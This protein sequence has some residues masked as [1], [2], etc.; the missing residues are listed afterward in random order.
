MRIK[1]KD[2]RKGTLVLVPL[3]QDD[4]WLLS[5]V[6][7]KGALVSGHTTRKIK[8]SE[9]KVDKK[10][11]YLQI[12]TEKVEYVNESLRVSGKS[13]TE[14]DDIPKG[15]YH[16]ISFAVH[17]E[18][19]I[20]QEWMKYQLDKIDESA[21]E[22]SNILL[23]V[24]DRQEVFFAQ[25]TQEGYKLLSS[26]EGDVERK[27]SG[28]K[29]KGEFYK[30]IL[31]KIREYDERLKLNHIIIATPAF[32][33]DDFM[34]QVNDEIL[35]KKM[36]LS[37]CSIA[38]EN[39]FSEVVKRDEVK[40]ALANERIKK[41]SEAVDE[42]FTEISKD[43]KFAYG[44]ESVKERADAGAVEKLLLSTNLI[45]VFREKENFEELEKIMKAVEKSNGEVVIITSTNEAGK[46]LDGI[47]GIGALL[48]YKQY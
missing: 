19:K 48:K 32:F 35:K 11:Y 4:L 41:E 33:K 16:T 40:K 8:I 45:N 30:D 28:V 23:A 34:K 13:N 27:V 5:Q 22:K 3:N 2:I 43:A 47:S 20:E 39:A 24:F 9:T 10:T 46:R 37:T 7:L 21:K 6:I 17:D 44:L 38:S 14:V 42:L 1:I 18:I 15:S 31:A 26:F 36:I 25:L 12:I 29:A